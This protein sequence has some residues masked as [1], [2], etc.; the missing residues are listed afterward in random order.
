[1]QQC[2]KMINNTTHLL[3]EETEHQAGH[4]NNETYAAMTVLKLNS[5]YII[6]FY[7]RINSEYPS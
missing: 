3:G 6:I 1:M 4:L 7:H 5:C 2:I